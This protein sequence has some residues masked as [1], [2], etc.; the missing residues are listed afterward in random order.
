[1][2]QQAATA[3]AAAAAQ[4][5]AVAGNIPGPGSVGGI[6]PAIS[7][8]HIKV[9]YQLSPPLFAIIHFRNDFG[10]DKLNSIMPNCGLS[11]QMCKQTMIYSCSLVSLSFFVHHSRFQMQ[12]PLEAD[13][14]IELW[15]VSSDK[16]NRGSQPY[17]TVAL[18]NVWLVHV[19]ILFFIREFV[20]SP[21]NM[22]YPYGEL[23]G[24]LG[25]KAFTEFLSHGNSHGAAVFDKCL[26]CHEAGNWRL[27]F[28]WDSYISYCFLNLEDG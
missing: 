5:A 15:F 25:V 18:Y 12:W 11:F 2:Q 4:A 3:Q 13:K 9:N 1:M 20:L 14:L 27:Q 10:R 16:T 22:T 19:S 24:V 17:W 23:T 6:A 7:K 28:R 26:E 21:F 8:W